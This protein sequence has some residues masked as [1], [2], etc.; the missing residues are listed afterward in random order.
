MERT[1]GVSIRTV[2]VSVLWLAVFASGAPAQSPSMD[3]VWRSQGYGNVFEIQGTTLKAFEVTNTTCVTAETAEVDATPAPGRI[4]TFKSPG[5]E[6][7][8]RAVGSTDHR[9][10][11]REGSASDER[12]ERIPRRP[13][14]CDH[15]TEN[16]PSGN[17]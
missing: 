6:M 14:V 9:L 2:C 13:A 4:A 15:P 11:H 1:R 8:V 12:I 5:G 7:F 10:L 16:T 17:F 3:G